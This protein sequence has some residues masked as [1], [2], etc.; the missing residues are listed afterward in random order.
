MTTRYGP[1]A[2]WAVV[3]VVGAVTFAYRYS[4]IY[5]FGR[6]DA[7]PPNLKAALR[8]VPP[9]VLA[10]LV[11]PS[12]VTVGPTPAAT[13]TDDRLLAGVVAGVVAWHTENM[14]ATIAVGMGALWTLR[15]LL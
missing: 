11:L 1:A 7:V 9:A 3:V 15:F 4:F 5:L 6:I 8:F 12:L 10:A 13:L 14:L 2:I